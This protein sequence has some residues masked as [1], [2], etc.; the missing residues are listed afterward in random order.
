MKVMKNFCCKPIAHGGKQNTWYTNK[1]NLFWK[2]IVP[3]AQEYWDSERTGTSTSNQDL[4]SYIVKKLAS[5]IYPIFQTHLRRIVGHS[6]TTVLAE[7]MVTCK[8]MKKKSSLEFDRNI[9][10][11]YLT[12]I[13]LRILKHMRTCSDTQTAVRPTP[14]QQTWS[15]FQAEVHPKIEPHA[16]IKF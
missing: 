15:I 5:W 16:S 4:N 12:K 2:M 6:C 3:L 14:Q 13:N 11:D 8:T 9:E 1:D 10:F 7:N